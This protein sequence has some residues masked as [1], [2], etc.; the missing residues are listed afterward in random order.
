MRQSN[1]YTKLITN[2]DEHEILLEL[3]KHNKQDSIESSKNMVIDILETFKYLAKEA[4]SKSE[5]LTRTYSQNRQQPNKPAYLAKENQLPNQSIA[6]SQLNT[7]VT[8]E[9]LID[10]STPKKE[11]QTT[12]QITQ[13]EQDKYSYEIFDPNAWKNNPISEPNFNH[14]NQHLV[15]HLFPILIKMHE[16]HDKN[17]DN[18]LIQ[19]SIDITLAELHNKYAT[20]NSS[21]TA[22]F[23]LDF[24]NLGATQNTHVNSNP[25]L[26]Y[27]QLNHE[28]YKSPLESKNDSVRSSVV[29]STT[30]SILLDATGH[31]KNP[32]INLVKGDEE[33]PFENFKPEASC[34]DM[35]CYELV[36]Y[37]KDYNILE[38]YLEMAKEFN[39]VKALKI[40][41]NE[42]L[43]NFS[44]SL[45][46]K[47]ITIFL[48]FLSTKYLSEIDKINY[49]IPDICLLLGK[50]LVFEAY[51]KDYS[52]N[53]IPESSQVAKPN[54][55]T[56]S[57]LEVNTSVDSKLEASNITTPIGRM[58]N[59]IFNFSHS[60]PD[61]FKKE[62]KQETQSDSLM[63]NSNSQDH[64]E[65]MKMDDIGEEEEPI[66]SNESTPT[67]FPK[68]KALI[69]G[70]PQTS[71]TTQAGTQPSKNLV[72]AVINLSLA[73]KDFTNNLLNHQNFNLLKFF[74][75][76]VSTWPENLNSNYI[77]ECLEMTLRNKQKSLYEIIMSWKICKYKICHNIDDGIDNTENFIP[78]LAHCIDN[79]LRRL[80]VFNDLGGMN[81]LL[82]RSTVM[83]AYKIK[84][85]ESLFS[86]SDKITSNYQ[87][88]CFSPLLDILKMSSMS[89][90]TYNLGAS[91]MKRNSRLLNPSNSL[92]KKSTKSVCNDILNYL[93]QI[94][95]E[96]YSIVDSGWAIIFQIVWDGLLENHGLT[97]N[98]ELIYQIFSKYAVEET[99]LLTFGFLPCVNS[100]ISYLKHV[101]EKQ[102]GEYL[103][104]ESHHRNQALIHVDREFLSII[105]DL[106][107]CA[108][109][110][111]KSNFQ[112]D[113]QIYEFKKQG[114]I[115]YY[116]EYLPTGIKLLLYTIENLLSA[117][118]FP[119]FTNLGFNILNVIENQTEPNSNKNFV[120]Y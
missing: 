55:G 92:T 39:N 62:V 26:L 36:K 12:N 59:T 68:P 47:C 71:E 117:S 87:V 75:N 98:L 90:A 85:I 84:S 83:E 77:F 42:I 40:L 56:L 5:T 69:S 103:K 13:P 23:H 48:K 76:L 110:S 8:S 78:K 67:N 28:F 1:I 18:L 58:S 105:E 22:N 94:L 80:N 70:E 44:M 66:N 21:G 53:V 112:I 49:F 116:N 113:E 99:K 14:F 25:E 45:D 10:L 32:F 19:L 52:K 114:A 37:T 102:N 51:P 104:T 72:L 54:R 118:I 82:V 15:D 115:M 74:K 38:L 50:I 6:D 106:C 20:S 43:K 41:F 24:D 108:F 31:H 101:S 95:E 63:T 86:H 111:S 29:S 30:N 27:L 81:D 93:V 64:S 46:S 2:L 7:S 97:R 89:D 109:G 34:F 88:Y 107:L 79:L 9:I 3:I 60:I 119:D 96:H 11:R 91:P 73:Y 33:S 57:P 120:N 65:D 4:K 100:I 17:L 16:K 35:I 61:F